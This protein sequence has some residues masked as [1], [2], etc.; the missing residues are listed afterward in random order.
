MDSGVVCFTPRKN[1]NKLKLFN[2][3]LFKFFDDRLTEK[4]TARK[5]IVFDKSMHTGVTLQLF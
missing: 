2:N 5:F 1:P 4:E 3:N